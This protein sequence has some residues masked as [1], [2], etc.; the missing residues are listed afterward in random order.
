MT[1]KS[2]F[3]ESFGDAVSDATAATA[4]Y[5]AQDVLSDP[6]NHTDLEKISATASVAAAALSKLPGVGAAML[7]SK[8]TALAISSS[9]ANV[10]ED[11]KTGDV[12]WTDYVAVAGA[13]LSRIPGVHVIKGTDLFI[14]CRCK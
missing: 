11:H 6:E 1:F 14:Q 13:F 2:T 8:A 5:A 3:N 12:S 9:I 10:A 7:A 4:A